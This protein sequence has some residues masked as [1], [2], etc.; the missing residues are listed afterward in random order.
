MT[1]WFNAAGVPGNSAGIVSQTVRNEFAAIQQNISEKLPTLTGNGSKAIFVN[2]GA[3]GLE[4]VSATTARTNLG[5][6]TISTQDADTVSITGGAVDGTVI[7]AITPAAASFTALSASTTLAVTGQTTLQSQ[8]DIGG[9]ATGAASGRGQ[10]GAGT[11]NGLQLLGQGTTYDAHLARRD[12]SIALGVDANTQNISVVGTF[13]ANVGGERFGVQ[14]D[15]AGM[16]F[17]GLDAGDVRVTANNTTHLTLDGSGNTS[18]AGSITVP[19]TAG[20]YFGNGYLGEPDTNWGWLLKPDTA[21]GGTA[22]GAIL[23]SSSAA[24]LSFNDSSKAAT[25]AGGVTVNAAQLKTTSSA[26]NFGLEVESTAAS[27]GLVV[28]SASAL[29]GYVFFYAGGTESGRITGF[30][31]GGG[32]DFGYGSS[33]TKA[34]G[35]DSGGNSTFNGRVTVSAGSNNGLVVNDGTVNG[36]AYCSTTL[37][38]SFA[39]GTTTAHPTII[40]AGNTFPII[41]VN[42]DSTVSLADDLGL[43]N[44]QGI[45]WGSSDRAFVAGNDGASSD[46][47]VSLGVNSAGLTLDT[48]NNATF[49]ASVN[50]NNSTAPASGVELQ[51]SGNALVDGNLSVGDGNTLGTATALTHTGILLTGATTCAVNFNAAANTGSIVFGASGGGAGADDLAFL[52]FN[53]IFLNLPT[54]AGT[55]GSLW[56]DG[57]TVKVS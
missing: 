1:D 34:F 20:Y 52:N 42:T 9:N 2:S 19:H 15:G 17:G 41:T 45:Y 43:S 51:V 38:N 33:A 39:I 49:S 14:Q 5:L 10:I 35:F 54:S 7:G 55:T 16:Y 3:T 24:L 23:D 46:G 22:N 32:M 37:T 48:S 8:I 11:I 27:A 57:G 29:A 36:I 6:G 18:A 44:D 53:E 56:N 31:G 30:G 13:I 50:I 4:A 28:K 12:G 40:G 26:A 25:F 47:Y 21:S